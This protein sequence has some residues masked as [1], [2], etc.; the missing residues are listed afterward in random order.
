[1][2]RR[3]NQATEQIEQHS[4]EHAQHI[5][6][7][8]PVLR[9]TIGVLFLAGVAFGI[10]Y[11]VF[12]TDLLDPVLAYAQPIKDGIEWVAEEPSRLF[13]A[14]AGILL[15]HIGLFFWINENFFDGR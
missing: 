10:Y 1:M 7:D 9:R 12:L 11:V 4:A 13:A 2:A 8:H 6:K 14:A 3:R 15:P 5:R